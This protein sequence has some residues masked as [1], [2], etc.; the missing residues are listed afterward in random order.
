MSSPPRRRVRD[1]SGTLHQLGRLSRERR[2]AL[3]LTQR[4]LADLAGV[5]VSSVR[6]LEGGRETM[7]LAVMLRICDALGLA[8]VV[9]PRPTAPGADAVV[10][11]PR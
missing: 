9:A 7:S 6:A 2:L 4:D 3:G 10:L 11:P 8:L 5:G 1:I